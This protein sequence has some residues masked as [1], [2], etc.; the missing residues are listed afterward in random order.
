MSEL[1][2][3]SLRTEKSPVFGGW[4]RLVTRANID[5]DTTLMWAQCA[6]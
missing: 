5:F 6:N 3:G 1:S 2:M 4:T